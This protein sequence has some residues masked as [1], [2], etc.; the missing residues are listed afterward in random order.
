MECDSHVPFIGPSSR[1]LRVTVAASGDQD[2]HNQLW[3][4]LQ[5]PTA[6]S[7]IL[8]HA[9]CPQAQCVAWVRRNGLKENGPVLACTRELGTLDLA[10]SICENRLQLPCGALHQL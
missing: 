1:L 5:A 6:G 7:Q 8:R 3:A 9:A 10:S 2:R 4:I